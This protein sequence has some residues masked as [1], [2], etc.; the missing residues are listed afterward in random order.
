MRHFPSGILIRIKPIII[1]IIPVAFQIE[2][3]SFK[4]KV[5]KTTD[6]I[7]P[8]LSSGC[9]VDRLPY[10]NAIIMSIAPQP[11]SP[12]PTEINISGT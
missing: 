11:Y 4:I 6:K 12:N 10:R 5:P 9:N 3:G 2:I 7:Y 1:V 8:V